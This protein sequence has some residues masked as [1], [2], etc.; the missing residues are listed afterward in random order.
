V[1][2]IKEK[3][4]SSNIKDLYVLE[5][6]T[7][8]DVRGEIWT[9]FSNEH[10]NLNYVADK[11]TISRFGVLRGFHGDSHTAKLITCL[12][13]QFQLAAADLRADSETYGNVETFLI[14]DNK[15]SVVFVPAGCVNAHLCLSDKCVFHYKWSKDYN[16]P[17][18]Q[19]TV[20]WNDPDL[21]VDWVINNPILSKR[22]QNG[23]SYK[24]IK[25]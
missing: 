24:Q 18:S 23:V 19:V 5:L 25:L 7:F 6:D 8:Q 13:G 1:Q 11:V 17:D 15:P 14:S 12:S 3:Y 22:D 20:A 10:S 4:V 2:T 21:S 16:G 9:I